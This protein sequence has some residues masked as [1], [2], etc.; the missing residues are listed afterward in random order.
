MALTDIVTLIQAEFAP[1]K[2]IYPRDVRDVLI[3]IV[4]AYANDDPTLLGLI[5]T[6][7]P[8]NNTQEIDPDELRDVLIA[9][10]GYLSETTPISAQLNSVVYQIGTPA[11]Q[12]NFLVPVE[13]VSNNTSINQL[14][15]RISGLN[16]TNCEVLS[17]GTQPIAPETGAYTTLREDEYILI[18][19]I[20]P[21]NPPEPT[22]NT[23]LFNSTDYL[24]IAANTPLIFN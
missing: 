18:R 1:N 9:I 15:A 24:L 4:A 17:G 14:I 21:Y 22:E 3:A 13:Q 23:L 10:S 5:N 7:V 6:M 16:A 12:I 8:D 11:P 2:V 19:F 20:E